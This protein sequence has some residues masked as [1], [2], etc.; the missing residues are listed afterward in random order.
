MGDYTLHINFKADHDAHALA[1]A[2]AYVWTLEDHKNVPELREWDVSGVDEGGNL[3]WSVILP[4]GTRPARTLQQ[5]LQTI[6]DQ[7]QKHAH[8][9]KADW[10][11]AEPGHYCEFTNGEHTCFAPAKWHY[12]PKDKSPAHYAFL[13]WTHKEV[14]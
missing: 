8:K 7:G 6:H 3:D 1:L 4:R 5:K 14:I 11:L 9:T 2:M 12:L 13:C 10:T